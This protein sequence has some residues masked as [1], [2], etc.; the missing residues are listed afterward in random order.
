MSHVL[1][2]KLNTI[3][4]QNNQKQKTAMGKDMC[5]LL[6]EAKNQLIVKKGE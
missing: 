3:F 2:K 4:N 1:T 6:F 5:I